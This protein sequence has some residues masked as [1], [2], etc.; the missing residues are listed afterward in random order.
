MPI[1]RPVIDLILSVFCFIGGQGATLPETEALSAFCMSKGSRKFAPVCLSVCLR[2][3]LRYT[4]AIF[5]KFLCML[6]MAVARS[7]SVDTLCTSG[8]VDAETTLQGCG[9]GR[10]D[11]A[12][13]STY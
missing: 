11:I 9:C 5:N 1:L 2:E 3:Y 13:Q 4:R 12:P 8:F 7:S 10:V 6:P